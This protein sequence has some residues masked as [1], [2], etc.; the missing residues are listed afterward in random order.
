MILDVGLPGI[1]PW[2]EDKAN[3]LLRH[4]NFHQTPNVP[5]HLIADRQ[6][7]YFREG[8]FNRFALNS[9]AITDSDVTHYAQSYG[10]PAQLRAGLEFYRAFPAN[11]KFN[12]AQRSTIDVPIVLAGGDN[13]VGRFNPK[14]AQSLRTHGCA[15]VAIEV[16]KNSGHFVVDEQ[17]DIVVG[18]IE[19]HASSE[20]RGK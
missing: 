7:I 8:L 14:I 11:E 16:I 5:E 6:F 19:R 20:W 2:E 4:F 18:L 12:A 17:P 9:K 13:S 1:E 3:P 10:A 15:N